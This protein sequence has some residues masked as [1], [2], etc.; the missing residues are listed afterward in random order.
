M[1]LYEQKIIDGDP[2][3]IGIAYLAFYVKRCCAGF[4]FFFAINISDC[5]QLPCF[6]YL[7]SHKNLARYHFH[8]F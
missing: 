1:V 7:S 4:I 3:G 6:F 5:F 2:M 8:I